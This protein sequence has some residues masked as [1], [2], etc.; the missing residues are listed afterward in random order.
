MSGEKQRNGRAYLPKA[1]EGRG[2]RQIGF[3]DIGEQRKAS[4]VHVQQCV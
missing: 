2:H 3:V 4:A 1:T